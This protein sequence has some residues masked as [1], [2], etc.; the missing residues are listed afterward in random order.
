MIE[1]RDV[2]Q[3]HPGEMADAEAYPIKSSSI[4]VIKLQVFLLNWI[5]MD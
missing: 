2:A 4:Q 5:V 1:Q 3:L